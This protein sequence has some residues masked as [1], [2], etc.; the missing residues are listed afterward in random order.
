MAFIS[1]A[2][3]AEKR[4]NVAGWRSSLSKQQQQQ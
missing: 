2:R 1:G 4:H 3:I